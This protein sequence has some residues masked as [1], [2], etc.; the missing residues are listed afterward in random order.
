VMVM[1]RATH[2]QLLQ[3]TFGDLQGDD[4]LSAMRSDGVSLQF[5]QGRIN[6]ILEATISSGRSCVVLRYVQGV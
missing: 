6:E 4:V 5:V 3:R 1:C 2:H